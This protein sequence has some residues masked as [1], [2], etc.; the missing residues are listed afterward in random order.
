MCR[1]LGPDVPEARRKH[2]RRLLGWLICARRPLRWFE[3]QCAV[4]L[5]LHSG[6]MLPSL[7]FVDDAK[8]L[9]QSLVTIS[10]DQ[11]VTL[12]HSTLKA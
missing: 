7:R 5:D 10:S 2:I 11:T 1:V 12:V 6:Q 3:V 9:C 8:D 4:S